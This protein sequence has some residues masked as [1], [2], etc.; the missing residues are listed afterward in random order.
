MTAAALLAAG[1]WAE[2]NT[3]FEVN[4]ITSPQTDYVLGNTGS[5]NI[6][7]VVN[8]GILDNTGDGTIGNQ[9]GA[10][11]NI[12]IVTG[13]GS[14]WTN[15]GAL[16]IGNTGSVNSLTVS[17]GGQVVSDDAALGLAPDSAGNWAA[18][19]G[20]GTAWRAAG[21]LTIGAT[22]DRNLVR[23]LGAA[24]LEVGGDLT[25]GAFAG[26]DGNELRVGNEAAVEVGGDLEV[27]CA[28]LS[29]VLTVADDGALTAIGMTVGAMAGA[30]GNQVNVSTGG[31]LLTFSLVVGQAGARNRMTLNGPASLVSWDGVIG[32]AAGS[33]GNQA[34]VSG[35]GAVLVCVFMDS[36]RLVVGSQGANNT[37]EARD[38]GGFLTDILIVGEEDPATNNAVYIRNGAATVAQEADVI[39]GTLTLDGGELDIQRLVLTNVAGSAHLLGG[40]AR[41]FE[42]RVENGLP[43]LAG[44]G[45]QALTV[46]VAGVASPGHVFEQGLVLNTN[47]V[48]A[49]T[50]TVHSAVILLPGAG[51]APGTSV[52]VLTVSN[53]TLSGEAFS[54]FEAGSNGFDCVAV[55]GTLA[56]AAGS[57]VTVHLADAGGAVFG[58]SNVLFTYGTL[59]GLPMR[60]ILDPGETGVA[61]LGIRHDAANRR[62]VLATN[63]PPQFTTEPVTSAIAGVAYSC[64][65]AAVDPDG[66]PIRL[67]APVLPPWLTLTNLPGGTNVL[68]G[69]PPEAGSAEV[70]VVADDANTNAV[71]SFIIHVRG[72]TGALAVDVTPDSGLWRLTEFPAEYVGITMGAGDHD[73]GQVPTGMY[74]MVFDPIP[75]HLPPAGQT[76]NLAFGASETFEGTYRRLAVVGD[77]D[78]DGRTDLVLYDAA[79]G[80]WYALAPDGTMVVWGIAWGGPGY[81]PVPGD[82]DGDGV[83]DLAVYHRATGLWFIRTVSGEV[84]AWAL[85]WGGPGY[86]PVAGDY[87][88]DGIWDLAVYDETAGRWHVSALDGSFA[89][90]DIP[91]G[92]VGLEPVPGDYNGD[93]SNDLAVYG[94]SSGTWYVSTVQTQVLA[95]AETW[96]GP[97]MI[98]VAGD[99]NGDGV[100]DLAVYH[101]SSGL[102]YIRT[103]GAEP[104]V[105]AW[106]LAWGWSGAWPVSGDY[107][108]DG[109]SDLA[110]YSASF[111][112][113][114]VYSLRT[115]QAIVW[116]QAWGGPGLWPVTW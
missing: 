13:A 90:L 116:N 53:L 66:D 64:A 59:A 38:G 51:L 91:W 22:G 110:V 8:G 27:G 23:V 58:N 9:A 114:F 50:G 31:T 32:D 28:G 93:R 20:T 85:G 44:G 62:F 77:Y 86:A 10:D 104:K 60:W 63:R 83:M 75:G 111:G 48:L 17:L 74:A 21:V 4:G 36:G 39:R 52:G 81:T 89:A 5:N 87:N 12:A 26:A 100:S 29:N 70:T 55:G 45:S 112:R 106:A 102:W 19:S 98:A 15:S 109:C 11:G 34:F 1:A 46:E 113:W 37:L 99:Y 97:A 56:F 96:G 78:G 33:D 41:L 24:T 95:W 54:H 115:G 47:A 103:L 79:A 35:T 69:T 18:V 67:T 3:F 40:Y 2:D 65:V 84:L 101:T 61:G 88:G 42:S 71:L 7:L 49:G 76:R 72:R 57:T 105:L 94:R 92:G 43:L 73:F 6:L 30:D 68:V 80:R 14:I 82:Y 16:W 107:D 25:L 108:G